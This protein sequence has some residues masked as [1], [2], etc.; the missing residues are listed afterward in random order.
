MTIIRKKVVSFQEVADNILFRVCLRK[1]S[2]I[3]DK[4]RAEY[5]AKGSEPQVLSTTAVVLFCSGK[6]SRLVTGNWTKPT[7]PL[8]I[9]SRK[10]P[11]ELLIRSI[12]D[13]IGQIVISVLP[14]DTATRKYLED[15]NFFGKDASK[16]SYIDQPMVIT[17]DANRQDYPG[18]TGTVFDKV[19]QSNDILSESVENVVFMDGEKMGVE[20]KSFLE[21]IGYHVCNDRL[22]SVAAYPLIEDPKHKYAHI[23]TLTDEAYSGRKTPDELR[24]DTDEKKHLLGAGV[25]IAR[26]GVNYAPLEAEAEI[27]AG[28]SFEEIP[29]ISAVKAVSSKNET[30][31]IG[32]FQVE[33]GQL[34]V[35]IKDREAVHV[36]INHITEKYRKILLQ[37]GW[38]VGDN[39]LIEMYGQINDDSIKSPNNT[40]IS[41]ATLFLSGP[42]KLGENNTF[43]GESLICGLN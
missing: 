34:G 14:G 33:R 43:K 11:L 17:Q 27:K 4:H 28:I 21:F 6:G 24:L 30:V 42:S 5:L 1:V 36:N 16:F 25:Y 35:G 40:L 32:Y 18:G 38:N 26:K 39:V 37:A 7:L 23:N 29:I 10:T 3:G 15:N 41:G 12:S 19:M 20:A 2:T 22:F 31:D 8:P 9:P 13:D